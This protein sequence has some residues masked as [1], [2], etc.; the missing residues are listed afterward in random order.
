MPMEMQLNLMWQKANVLKT[1]GQLLDDSLVGNF[2]P[3]IL[4]NSLHHPDG[5]G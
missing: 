3:D 4:L 1:I 2:P 5:H